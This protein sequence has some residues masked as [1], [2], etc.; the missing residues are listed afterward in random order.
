[1]VQFIC[2]ECGETLKKK[3]VDRHCES[4]CRNG[5]Y[6]TCLECN[7]TFAGFEYTEHNECMTEK[8]KFQG[9]FLRKKEQQKRQEKKNEP[10]AQPAPAASA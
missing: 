4:V 8:E 2:E 1:M 7:K 9:H 3:Q 5:W 6:F 10:P